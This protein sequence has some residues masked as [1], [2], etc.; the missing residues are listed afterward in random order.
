MQSPA[1]SFLTPDELEQRHIVPLLRQHFP[2]L[3]AK[4]GLQVTMVQPE[5]VALAQ[6]TSGQPNTLPAQYSYIYTHRN[7]NCQQVVYILANANGD[8]LR[9][10][11]SK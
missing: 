10:L 4:L 11:I 8:I 1:S 2:T 5:R 7:G 3:P 6:N 9:V